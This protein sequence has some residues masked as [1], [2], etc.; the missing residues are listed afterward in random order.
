MRNIYDLFIKIEVVYSK[1]EVV[2]FKFEVVLFKIYVI[3]IDE[4]LFILGTYSH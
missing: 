3:D 1:I 2:L 4:S